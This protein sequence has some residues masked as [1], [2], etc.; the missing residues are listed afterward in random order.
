MENRNKFYSYEELQ[1]ELGKNSKLK[2]YA[3]WLKWKILID[4]P[5]NPGF[6]II[7]KEKTQ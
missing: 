6:I 5:K 1:T 3:E 7:P 4:F 2:E